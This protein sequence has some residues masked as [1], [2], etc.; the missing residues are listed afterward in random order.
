MPLSNLVDISDIV[1]SIGRDLVCLDFW[2]ETQEEVQ[3]AQAAGTKSLP[4]VTVAGLPTGVT[5]VRVVAMFMARVIENTNEAVN[6]LDGATVAETSQVI[7]VRSDEPGTWQ[8]AIKFVDDQFGLAP[9]TREGGP[10]LTG[11]VDIS[12][13]VD[14]NDTYEFQWLLAKADQDHL[15]FNDV[16]VGLRLWYTTHIIAPERFEYYV[17]GDTNSGYIHGATWYA[18]SFTPAA[19]H[20]LTQIKL[21]MRKFAECTGDVHVDVYEADGAHKPTG[22]SIS[23]GTIP[24]VNIE[25]TEDPGSFVTCMMSKVALT[26]DK[27]YVIVV[28]EPEDDMNG[29]FWRYDADSSYPRGLYLWSNDGGASWSPNAARDLLFEE[30]GTSF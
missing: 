24:I 22:D 29:V 25:D 26:V 12:E 19:A 27:E 20:T 23:T 7:Q 2:S 17:L 21:K 30:W 13:E 3:L 16:Q 28:S 8:D 1:A 10:A 9:T 15:Q 14:G 18:Q 11:S 6:K 5:V 4:S